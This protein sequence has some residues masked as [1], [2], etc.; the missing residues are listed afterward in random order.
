[1][2]TNAYSAEWFSLF[3]HRITPEQTE[4]EVSF[5]EQHLEVGSWVLDSPCGSGRH[6]R[7]LATRGYRIIALDRDATL[8][9]PAA[10]P[11]VVWICADLQAL[12]LAAG[13]LDAVLCLWQSFGYFGSEENADLLREWAHLVRPGGRLILDLYHR[14]FFETHTGERTLEHASGP[15]RERRRMRGDRLVVELAYEGPGGGDRF[16]WQLFTPEDLKALAER[17]GWQLRLA[18]SDFDARQTASPERPRV[19]YVLEKS[20]A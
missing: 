1:M 14:G 20:V 3:L 19:Q 2:L 8:L 5:I 17:C 9:G 15:I 18:C 12:P 11:S 16:D 6:A 10:D 4:R 7:L 13:R